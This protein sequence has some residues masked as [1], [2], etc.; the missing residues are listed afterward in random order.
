MP[1]RLEFWPGTSSGY[2]SEPQRDV[3]RIACDHQFVATRHQDEGSADQRPQKVASERSGQ[4]IMAVYLLGGA[5]WTPRPDF[6]VSNDGFETVTD[7]EVI[8]TGRIERMAAVQDNLVKNNQGRRG[9]DNTDYRGR[10]WAAKR[11][12][13]WVFEQVSEWPKRCPRCL[14]TLWKSASARPNSH[15]PRAP[16]LFGQSA[17]H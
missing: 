10:R 5:R 13:L 1:H 15:T 3:A 7:R 11:R 16:R 4:W 9:F 14:S 8:E 2:R 17:S 12:F 6:A